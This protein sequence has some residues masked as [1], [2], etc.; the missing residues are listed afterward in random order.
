M[1]ADLT[2][3]RQEYAQSLLGKPP[4]SS[5]QEKASYF[6]DLRGA[7]PELAN[8]LSPELFYHEKP[9]EGK[10]KIYQQPQ[11]DGTTKPMRLNI[12]T[13]EVTDAGEGY[14]QPPKPTSNKDAQIAQTKLAS[15]KAAKDQLQKVKDNF[16]KL[17]GTMSAG[18][19]GNLLP[20]EEGKLF[21]A[22]VDTMRG[23]IQGVMKTPGLGSQSD[24]DA[25]LDQAKIPSR[26]NYENVTQQQIDDLEQ[27]INTMEQGYLGAA[28]SSVSASNPPKNSQTLS[29]ALTP[30]EEA[31]LQSLRKEFGKR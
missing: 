10:Y 26:G 28:G 2:K 8:A 6:N 12:E 9:N 14:K 23:L 17:K 1:E 5:F 29:S 31:E 27:I 4:G 19:G 7:N 25:K 15:I 22:S 11:P 20:T 21:D 16:S 24:Y 18:L 13:G 3:R 30:E